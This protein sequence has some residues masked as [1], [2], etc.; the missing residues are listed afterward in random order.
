MN[1]T[2]VGE[3]N[4]YGRDPK[5]ALYPLPER[6]AGGRLCRVLGMPRREYLMRFKRVNLLTGDRDGFRWSAPTAR[7]AAVEVLDAADAGDALVLLGAR[8]T[9][10]F[11]VEFAPLQR[12]QRRTL[13]GCMVTT[14]V[15][16]HPSGRSRLWNDPTMA[17]RA[18]DAVL[19]LWSRAS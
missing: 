11:G 5:Y 4:P 18:R 3:H 6:S 14:L 19:A 17:A 7:L 10:A 13:G 8:V 16:P 2:L 9:A 1:V 12:S 15:L